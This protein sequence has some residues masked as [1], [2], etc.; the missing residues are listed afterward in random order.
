MGESPHSQE[1]K[2]ATNLST[3]DAVPIAANKANKADLK[4]SNILNLQIPLPSR[5]CRKY[6][7]SQLNK[8]KE[9]LLLAPDD[10]YTTAMDKMRTL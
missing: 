4:T 1:P 10:A 2:E 3:V 6:I 5:Q 9:F 7:S 8:G